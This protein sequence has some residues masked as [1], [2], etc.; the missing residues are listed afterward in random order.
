MKA[1]LDIN[2][3]NVF[4]VADDT[5][6]TKGQ[7]FVPIYRDLPK[8][9]PLA[10]DSEE[11][12]PKYDGKRAV[13]TYKL[14]ALTPAESYTKRLSRGS[15]TDAPTGLKLKI[16]ES[17]QA[18]F[19]QQFTLLTAALAAGVTNPQDEQTFY[20]YKDEEKKLSTTDLLALLLRYGTYCQKVFIDYAP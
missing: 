7:I 17:A 4:L 15:Y 20:D 13:I 12:A 1:L 5:A 19:T 3:S 6:P 8:H 9:D 11:T 14:K 16:T 10:Y 2:T 18:K